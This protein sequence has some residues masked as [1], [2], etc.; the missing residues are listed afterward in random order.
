MTNEY[1]DLPSTP[2]FGRLI[3]LYEASCDPANPMTPFRAAGVLIAEGYSLGQQAAFAVTRVDPVG[4]HCEVMRSFAIQARP[5]F[6][7]YE[8]RIS[9]RPLG[10]PAGPSLADRGLELWERVQTS[11]GDVDY[12]VSDAAFTLCREG[13]PLQI[14]E[15]GELM[16]ELASAYET[17]VYRGPYLRTKAATMEMDA[18]R[19]GPDEL[20]GYH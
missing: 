13:F 20:G 12:A 10:M 19:A 18:L 17:L 8:T 1:L 7:D 4:L 5:I 15:A 6:E 3:E 9:Q 2:L 14:D 11:H 16:A